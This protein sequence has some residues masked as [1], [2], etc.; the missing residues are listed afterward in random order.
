MAA[1]SRPDGCVLDCFAPRTVAL[2]LVTHS[3]SIIVPACNK[4]ARLP[5]TP[6]QAPIDDPMGYY[7]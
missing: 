6:G 3:F 5:E 4:S 7:Q 2:A 1:E